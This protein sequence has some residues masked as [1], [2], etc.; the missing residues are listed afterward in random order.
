MTN[1]DSTAL[2]R[3]ASLCRTLSL[4]LIVLLAAGLTLLTVLSAAGLLPWLQLDAAFGDTPLPQAGMGLQI[5]LTAL[6]LGLCFFLPS[7]VR[8]QRLETSHRDFRI[9]MEDV[10]R[11]YHAVHAQDREGAFTLSSQFDSVRERLAFLR[12]HP[13]LRKLEPEVLEVAAQMSETSR[14]LAE[15]YSSERIERART[16]LRQRQE[17]AETFEEQLSLAR[18]TLDEIK[19]WTQRLNVD[20]A[21][22]QTQLAQLERDLEELLP[23]L[24]LRK[25]VERI[26]RMALEESIVSDKPNVVQLDHASAPKSGGKLTP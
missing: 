1:S 25:P 6:A 10:A 18:T 15:I 13:D 24:G 17:E 23:A 14:E 5:G 8:M 11:A 22:R 3:M 16:F 4:S 7:N 26:D 9:R 2:G 21:V 20:E 19:R 12:N